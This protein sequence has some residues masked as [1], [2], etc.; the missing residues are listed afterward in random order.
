MK[1]LLL[2]LLCLPLIG[3]GQD[4]SSD[5]AISFSY[6]IDGM[7]NF[8]LRKDYN[9]EIIDITKVDQKTKTV[10]FGSTIELSDL[11]DETKV[12]YQI[13]GN[14]EADIE[15]GFI[16]YKSP[17]ASALIGKEKGDFVTVS[18]PKGEK[19]YEVIKIIYK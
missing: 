17:V 8:D 5:S 1:K 11:D 2:I 9:A 18:T 7:I 19:S 15:K 6:Y 12:K 10:V 4:N 13:V 3:F 14:D 16:S